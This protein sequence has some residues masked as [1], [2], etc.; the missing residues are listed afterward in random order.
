[1]I[2]FVI[3]S[4]LAGHQFWIDLHAIFSD[5]FFFQLY[6]E[7]DDSFIVDMLSFA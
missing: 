2:A 1:M 6:H 7:N 4:L 3:F 5:A